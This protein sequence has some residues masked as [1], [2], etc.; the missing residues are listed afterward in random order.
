MKKRI[1]PILLSLAIILSTVC[2][3]PI[4][5]YAEVD[6]EVGNTIQLT[7]Q[8]LEELPQDISAFF[9][10]NTVSLK[11]ADEDPLLMKNY[12][13]EYS[14]TSIAKTALELREKMI[15]REGTEDGSY[16]VQY[17][18]TINLDRLVYYNDVEVFQ[19]RLIDIWYLILDLIYDESTNT[20]PCGGDYLK[21]HVYTAGLSFHY[22]AIDHRV[23]IKEDGTFDVYFSFFFDFYTT[24]KQEDRVTR[25]INRVLPGII[26]GANNDFE[27]ILAIHDYICDETTYDD[28][29]AD[30]EMSSDGEY[31]DK[32]A[33]TAYGLLFEHESV[34]Q[35]YASLFYR[36]CNMI[37]IDSRI[38]INDIHG[39]NI[40]KLGDYYY[41]I[42]CTWDDNLIDG[43]YPSVYHH[44]YFLK[45]TER[46][47]EEHIPHAEFLTEE[48]AQAYPMAERDA[49][50]PNGEHLGVEKVYTYYDENDQ[51]EY[52]TNYPDC[53][54]GYY[55][56]DICVI[57]EAGLNIQYHEKHSSHEWNYNERF[58]KEADC[59]DRGYNYIKCKNCSVPGVFEYLEVNSNKHVPGKSKK[60]FQLEETCISTGLCVEEIHCKKCDE[61]IS[62]T[63]TDI[64]MYDHDYKLYS[65]GEEDVFS[66]ICKNEC[67][68]ISDFAFSEHYNESAN[69]DN[70][71][72]DANED[73]YINAKDFAKLRNQMK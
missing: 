7:H 51:S 49:V 48:F 38:I 12:M 6:N 58:V 72:L 64:P 46:F 8:E 30:R 61:L 27:K 24:K 70:S 32:T 18:Q 34:C 20:N 37:G 22:N 62:S 43:N 23:E 3:L 68:T 9:D 67:G 63:S 28:D 11:T 36:M 14:Y 19:Q 16:E 15:N 65:A 44:D 50:C 47:T 21:S 52:Y 69:T 39:W 41:D 13:D 54:E 55:E 10:D 73:G 25:E 17:D 35:G 29:A 40:V 59:T 71:I 26:A 56:Y 1:I 66:F 53:T 31:I 42:D 60:T 33:H 2:S 4:M 57:C 5:S 45:V